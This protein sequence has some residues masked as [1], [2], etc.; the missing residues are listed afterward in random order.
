VRGLPSAGR[1]AGAIVAYRPEPAKINR[2][3][4][5]LAH[6]CEAIYVV[7]NGGGAAS[8]DAES[9]ARPILRIVDMGGNSGLGRALN[10]A[11][12][13]L[14]AAEF[15]YLVTFDQDSEP[16]QGQVTALVERLARERASNKKTAAVGPLIVDRR[17]PQSVRHHFMGRIAGWPTSLHCAAGGDCV[18]T[19]FLITSGAVISIEAYRNVGKYDEALFVDYTDVDWCMRARRQGYRLLGICSVIMAHELSGGNSPNLL[20]VTILSYSPVRRY[21][22]ARNVV[23]L[24][25]RN[26]VEPGW[27]AR[28]VLGLVLR[29]ILLPV[30]ARFSRGWTRDWSMMV[31]GIAHG[32]CNRGGPHAG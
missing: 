15:D 2:L 26:Y 19:D 9:P 17:G 31:K 21:Y 16:N 7:D 24:A 25:R 27:K 32:L 10:A 18:E 22:Y 14:A 3:I 30:S 20:G 8:I 12:D 5:T 1:I 11:F 29:L 28:L 4:E 6:E 23:L 13:L